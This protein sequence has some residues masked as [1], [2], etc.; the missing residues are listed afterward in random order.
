M[1][2]TKAQS[3]QIVGGALKSTISL[4][5]LDK[6]FP[7]LFGVDASPTTANVYS[8]V[9]WMY[10]CV[11]LRC[12]TLSAIPHG[13]FREGDE[14]PLEELPA[15]YQDVDMER[16]LWLTEAARCLWG[17]S[18]WEKDATLHW[19]NPSTMTVEVLNNQI[20]AF[21]QET[22]GKP[23]TWQPDELVY[24]PLFGPSDDLGPG[25]APADVALRAAGLAGSLLQ[26]AESFFA[27]G[28]VPLVLLTTDQTINQNDPDLKR[29]GAM[30]DKLFGG[31]A[32]AHKTGVLS[33]GL[34]PTILSSP[35]KDLAIPELSDEVRE[36][37]AACFGIPITMLQQAAA[38]YATAKEDVQG[39]HINTNFPEAGRIQSGM[40]K[41]LWKPL[42]YEFR[43]LTDEVEAIQQNEA[44]KAEG[45][46][47]LMGAV[48]DQFDKKIL[49]RDR[50]VF[51]AERIWDQMGMPFPEDMP[52]EEPEPEP[53]PVIVQA[54]PNDATDDETPQPPEP[55][56]P[57]EAA[58]RALDMAAQMR[59]DLGKWARKAS[60]RGG[61]CPFE[62]DAIP[63]WATKTVH[64][65]LLAE[66]ETA[67]DPFLG[68]VK[69]YPMGTEKALAGGI[70]AI[71]ASQL[72]AIIRAVRAGKMPELVALNTQL[73]GVLIQSL[74]QV[75][76]ERALA[77]GA[78]LGW[79]I[80]YDEL[81]MNSE[82]WARERADEAVRL[83]QRTN[84]TRLQ[85]IIGDVTSGAVLPEVAESLAT[86]LFSDKRAEGIAAY[87]TSSALSESSH[88]LAD[89]M[90]TA[91]I[92]VIERWLTAE[93]ER[94]CP[95]CGPLD[96]A[97]DDEW[98]S[99]FPSGP[100]AHVN[101]RCML[102]VEYA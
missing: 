30:W 82:T 69:A 3:G 21:R 78:A 37:L 24:L 70:A 50:A 29:I 52:D 87:E 68:G 35:V 90:R 38:N 85:G 61:D 22:T 18:Y 89:S 7:E 31:V 83:T 71:Y 10:R 17:A 45:M 97:V 12:D 28:A 55:G 101:C 33:K 59:R 32:K 13:L 20:A 65:R 100:P 41:Q 34:T 99:Q 58:Q 42:G 46:T 2:I 95:I 16:L 98:G 15:P 14:E 67:F 79:G 66:P 53:A 57:P 73:R 81:L 62:S 4:N 5:D 75:A 72:P 64:M 44:E 102:V 86:R 84:Q 39:Y 74:Q 60:K 56:V 96:K 43:F 51:L 19:L 88:E 92:P 23:A 9:S 49:T 48:T 36:D 91:G 1:K 77:E 47:A 76:A 11:N 63:D 54:P 26:W 25:V 93:D 8:T 27:H 94:V 6:A 40:N 80:E